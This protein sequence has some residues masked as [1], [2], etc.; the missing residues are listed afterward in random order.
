M[1]TEPNRSQSFEHVQDWPRP[2]W[3]LRGFTGL[4]EVLTLEAVLFSSQIGFRLGDDRFHLE[5]G[6]DCLQPIGDLSV[7]DQ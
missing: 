2:I 4:L 3:L 5:K 7:T 6:G 1:V